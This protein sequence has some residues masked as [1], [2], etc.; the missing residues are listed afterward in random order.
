MKKLNEE[1]IRLFYE[2]KFIINSLMKIIIII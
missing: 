1:E 2:N